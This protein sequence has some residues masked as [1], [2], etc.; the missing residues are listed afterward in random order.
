MAG[1]FKNRNLIIIFAILVVLFFAG[2]YFK[3]KKYQQTLKTDLVNIDTSKIDLVLLY[4]QSG[5]KEEVSFLRK[6]HGWT[7][8]SGEV[9]ADAGKGNV[10]NI[11]S[12]LVTLK[13]DQLV[14]RDP[15]RWAEFHLTDSLGTRLVLKEGKKTRLDMMIGKF[16]YK[17]GQGGYGGYGGNQGRGLT[18][19]RLTDENDVYIVEGYL[20]MTFNQPFRNWRD[21]TILRADKA[22]ITKVSYDYP[23][24]SGF[25]LTMQDSVW[26]VDGMQPD[27]AKTAQLLSAL[28][29]KSASTFDDEFSPLNA[30]DF[31]LRIE[32]NNMQP[33][34]VLAYRTGPDQYVI[35]SSLN[36]DSY[37]S[38]GPEGVF[39]DIFRSKDVL[40]GN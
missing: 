39:R 24:D 23:M 19:V 16:D 14:T 34:S 32:G 10:R 33:I 40:T 13:A 26:M 20:A 15:D 2:R 17:P 3:N 37:F 27:S 9:T 31:Q 30:P 18:Y 12:D 8:S 1:K 25:V 7:V 11:F 36:P 35:N 38:S 29:R 5:N 22:N 6:G 28:S 21:Q 4:P